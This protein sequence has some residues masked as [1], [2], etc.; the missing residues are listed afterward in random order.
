MLPEHIRIVMLSATVENVMDFAEWVGRITGK[1]I[2]V[3]KTVHRPV[4]LE[5]WVYYKG[6]QIVKT[7]DGEFKE[8]QLR[9]YFYDQDQDKKRKRQVRKGAQAK[10]EDKK[11]NLMQKSNQKQRVKKITGQF[12]KKFDGNWLLMKQ[13]EKMKKARI[14][15]V[16]ELDDVVKLINKLKKEDMIPAIFFV[17][18]K[19]RL[20]QLVT[21]LAPQ[22]NLASRSERAQIKQFFHFAVQR[23]QP[24]DRE[25]YQL[26]MLEDFLLRGIGIHHG[27][28]LHI[29]KEIVEMLLQRG[30][31]KLLFATD[32]FAMGLNMPTKTV[33]FNGI[34]KH[35]GTEFRNLKPSEYTQMAGRAGRRGL[36]DRGKVISFFHGKFFLFFR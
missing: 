3:M 29:G 9:Q 7:K 32:S 18:S 1:K 33:V 17:F 6:L 14:P 23:L 34:S 16:N 15:K 28:L 8:K 26:R 35:D 19:A 31:I 5:H 21:E 4:P 10:L 20:T 24:Q 27:D 25:I 30:L 13:L 11:N 36:D 22:I 2:Y 12:R